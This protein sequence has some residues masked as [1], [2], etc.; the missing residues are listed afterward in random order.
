L[1]FSEYFKQQQR[2]CEAR[3]PAEPSD[4]EKNITRLKIRLPNDEGILMRRFRINDTLQV[5]LNKKPPG[6]SLSKI[7]LDSF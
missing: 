4:T 7:P 2:E 3:L 1:I 5:C 6:I